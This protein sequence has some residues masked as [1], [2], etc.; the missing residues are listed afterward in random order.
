M[1]A[2]YFAHSLVTPI[3]N[4]RIE[5]LRRKKTAL[6]VYTYPSNPHTI[7]SNVDITIGA[8]I[9]LQVWYSIR[10]TDGAVCLLNVSNY[11]SV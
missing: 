7:A 8:S 10:L 11:L 9:S 6:L 2:Q 1:K 3:I 4:T 5:L